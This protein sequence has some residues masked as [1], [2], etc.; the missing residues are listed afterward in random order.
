MERSVPVHRVGI[1]PALSS[2]GYIPGLVQV[3]DDFEHSPFGD[4]Q[5]LRYLPCG[6]PGLP[7]H[8]EQHTAVVGN[9]VPPRHV[10]KSCQPIPQRFYSE[11][12]FRFSESCFR[13]H[14]VPQAPASNETEPMAGSVPVQVA[15]P[16]I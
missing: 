14:S 8:G 2:P 9:E 5:L 12:K 10:C 16:R 1:G 4:P 11:P 3:G 13:V 7:D 6:D 15:S